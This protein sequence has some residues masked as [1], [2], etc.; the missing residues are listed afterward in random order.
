MQ[1]LYVTV[2]GVSKKSNPT[3]APINS[4]VYERNFDHHFLLDTYICAVWHK[5]DKK[6]IPD[7]DNHNA[8][9]HAKFGLTYFDTLCISY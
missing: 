7:L 2:M 8:Q 4:W 9:Q 1:A 5:I 3:L 6:R